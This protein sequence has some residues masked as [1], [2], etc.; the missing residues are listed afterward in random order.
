[1]KRRDFISKITEA[2][3]TLASEEGPHTK[4]RKKGCP[5]AVPRGRE[6]SP[7]VVRAW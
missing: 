2:G 6:I 3:W 4:F 5:F 7:G 1:M